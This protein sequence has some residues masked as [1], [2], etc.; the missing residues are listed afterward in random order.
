LR[1]NLKK[2]RR[3]Q[4]GETQ[5]S[6]NGTLFFNALIQLLGFTAG[7]PLPSPLLCF[8]KKT[9]KKT[10]VA[11]FGIFVFQQHIHHY[12]KNTCPG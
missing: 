11:G 8:L 4:S 7:Y 2:Y 3:F 1:F 10:P 6:F 5:I 12:E 9:K